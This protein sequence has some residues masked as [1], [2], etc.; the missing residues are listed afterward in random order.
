[1]SSLFADRW[2]GY[3][4]SRIQRRPAC[5]DMLNVDVKAHLGEVLAGNLEEIRGTTR[6][7]SE[8]GEDRKRYGRHRRVFCTADHDFMCDVIIHV[9]EI[10]LEA[11]AKDHDD[12]D[13]ERGR[14]APALDRHA[15]EQN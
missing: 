12:E 7:A 2:D 14:P 1:M 5:D 4:S 10:D 13:R 8:E 9:T 15:I 11:R 6:D 3:Q